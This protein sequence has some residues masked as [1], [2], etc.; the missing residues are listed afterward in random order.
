[1]A[2]SQVIGILTALLTAETGEYIAAMKAAGAEAQA[3]GKKLEKDLEP[4]QRSINNLV[5]QF[6][7]G[8]EIRRAKEYA[9]SIEKVGGATNLVATDQARANKAFT[10]AIEHLDKLGLSATADAQKFKALADATKQVTPP[11]DSIGASAMKMAS[12]LGLAFSAAAVINGIKNL[13]GNAIDAADRIDD[14]SSKLGISAE[15]VQRFAFAAEQ[16]GSDIEGVGTAIAKMNANLSG[17]SKDVVSMLKQLGLSFA[18]IRQMKPEDAFVAIG[19]A[20]GKI[21]DPML[22]AEAAVKLFG[23]SGQDMLPAFKQGLTEL[24]S[25][26]SVMTA[27][28]VKQLADAQDAWKKFGNEVTVVTAKILTDV[29][30]SFKVFGTVFEHFIATMDA[31]STG[32]VAAAAVAFQKFRIEIMLANAKLAQTEANAKW[33]KE[34]QGLIPHAL[35]GDPADA[36]KAKAQAEAYAKAITDIVEKWNG[37]ALARE[38]KKTADAFKNLTAAQLADEKVMERVTKDVVALA[39]AGAILPPQLNEIA[40]R[41]QFI[42][43][44]QDLASKVSTTLTKAFIDQH[45]ATLKNIP[46]VAALTAEFN[47]FVVTGAASIDLIDKLFK[48]VKLPPPPDASQFG[49]DLAADVVGA[50]QRAI[51]GGGNPLLSVANMLG[52]K[53]G[54]QLG[55]AIGNAIGG[56][57]GD[58]VAGAAGVGIPLIGQFFGAVMASESRAA[59]HTRQ[60]AEELR[61][62]QKQLKNFGIDAT[63]GKRL[64]EFFDQL[65]IATRDANGQ[66]R[67]ATDQLGELL[68]MVEGAMGRAGLSMDDAGS[69]TERMSRS[70]KQLISDFKVLSAQG[71]TTQQ[72]TKGNAT[73]LNELIGAALET[74]QKIPAAL[75]P[76]LEELIK[77]GLL[78]DEMK[79]KMLGIAEPAPWKEMEA[80][81]TEFGISL[82]ALGPQ[83][84]QA[85]LSETAEEFARKFQLLVD[86]G[87]DVGAVIGG[88]GEKANEFLANAKRW[89]LELPASMRPLFEKMIEAG[90]L[91]DEN[92]EKVKD[93]K[94]IKFGKTLAEEFEPL[95]AKLDELIEVLTNG[96]PKAVTEM[97]DGAHKRMSGFSF[98]VPVSVGPPSGFGT[99]D[100]ESN[101]SFADGTGGFKNFG[102]GTSATLHG[103]EQVINTD[104]AQGIAGMVHQAVT[105]GSPTGPITM[106]WRVNGRDLYR[107]TFPDLVAVL[108]NAQVTR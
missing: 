87:A 3:L 94:D 10:A 81:A 61:S 38:V 84:Q 9:A 92:G 28:Q 95:L 35:M 42:T 100:G 97:V 45:A 6:L 39:K 70:A 31:W 12:A 55:E 4:R 27:A 7:G 93:L 69:A 17:G 5:A 15:A 52:A 36:A 14:L 99:G 50:I 22:Q 73:A 59:A 34:Q 25:Q 80:V 88:M 67:G 19:E 56:A 62:L 41:Q 85:K 40:R 74:G 44:T 64:L 90:E 104:E 107:E 26:T 86:N 79:R 11:I 23:K 71:F 21:Q 58:A 72:I 1:M 105:S 32:G 68:E 66:L 33:L 57:V 29:I 76:M 96:V 102:K 54:K 89:G 18:D 49:A 91:V 16:T 43:A 60:N 24:M 83:F 78:T 47:K 13:I 20:I 101:N 77:A 108:R 53:F 106:V 46:S 30:S 2:G 8:D 82:E 103:W 51:E 37:A 63:D 65:G 48:G 75:R 98:H